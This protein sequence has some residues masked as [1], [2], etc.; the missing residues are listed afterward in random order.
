ML[1]YR[2]ATEKMLATVSTAISWGGTHFGPKQTVSSG[3]RV[4][5]SESISLSTALAIAI[6]ANPSWVMAGTDGGERREIIRESYLLFPPILLNGF[7]WNGAKLCVVIYNNKLFGCA[8]NVYL[9]WAFRLLRLL[10][11]SAVIAVVRFLWISFFIQKIWWTRTRIF[12]YT[13][14]TAIK[15]PLWQKRLAGHSACWEGDKDNYTWLRALKPLKPESLVSLWCKCHLWHHKA[16]AWTLEKA[17][18][19]K[20]LNKNEC[21]AF[22]EVSLSGWRRGSFP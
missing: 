3:P 17:E 22:L 4:T 6:L 18:Q 10:H 15:Q 11:R 8:Q 9:F 21:F 19:T 14:N 13:P 20:K 16:K 1:N 7:C 5:E 2:R 12:N